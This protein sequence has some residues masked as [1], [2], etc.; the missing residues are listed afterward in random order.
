MSP[1]KIKPN[2][3]KRRWKTQPG[4]TKD[5]FS[6]V[7]RKLIPLHIPTA[8]LEGY[9]ALTEK[10]QSLPW[11]QKPKAIFTSNSYFSDDIFKAWAAE[12]TEAGT[13][14]V[15]GQHGGHFGMTPWSFHEEHQISI[16]DT[17]VSWGWSD[18]KKPQVK[19]FGNLKGF[20]ENMQCDP[21]GG[22]LMVEMT[23][24]RYS[25][26][27]YAGPVAGQWLSYFQDQCS[28]IEALPKVLQEQILVRLYSHDEG[29]DQS[30]RWKDR[31]PNIKIDSWDMAI[32]PI[33][34]K[35]IH[36][37]VNKSRLLI[38]TYNATTCLESLA[39]NVPTLMFWNPEHWELL[40]EAKPYF[41]KLKSVGI[42][43][44]SPESAAKQMI[45]IWNNVS[46]WWES[47]EVQRERKIFCKRFAHIPQRPLDELEALFKGI[48]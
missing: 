46:E 11:P 26:H 28:F 41:N 27:M 47:N 42:L 18:L 5:P 48:K 36:H 39:W 23:M 7:V 37:L 24:P 25:Y 30:R 22:A 1:N 31:F 43:H 35:T 4:L 29:W 14:L 34:R 20:G 13:P 38:S 32:H 12:K 10:I 44:E 21:K 2:I 40:E 3:E 8:Y 16:S 19:A 9:E 15:I 45:A 33:N 17:W 6:E